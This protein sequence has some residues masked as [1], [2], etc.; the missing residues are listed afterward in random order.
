M[1]GTPFSLVV[2]YWNQLASLPTPLMRVAAFMTVCAWDVLRMW[3][4][5]QW[6]SECS[7]SLGGQWVRDAEQVVEAVKTAMYSSDTDLW[8][9]GIAWDTVE[10]AWGTTWIRRIGKM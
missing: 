9:P 7:G 1:L 4:G 5:L 2:Q 3:A 8:L 6:S 10:A